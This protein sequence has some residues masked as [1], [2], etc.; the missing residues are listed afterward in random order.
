VISM[1]RYG[2][3]LLYSGPFSRFAKLRVWP[4]PWRNT[5]EERCTPFPGDTHR[6]W[7]PLSLADVRVCTAGSS[8]MEVY[9]LVV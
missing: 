3:V 2:Y 7:Y 5:L 9:S 6:L 4:E 8:P 1:A